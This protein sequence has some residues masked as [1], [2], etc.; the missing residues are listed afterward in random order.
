VAGASHD[1][2]DEVEVLDALEAGDGGVGVAEVR[3]LAL[4]ELEAGQ[5]SAR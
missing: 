1:V 2:D 5:R 4:C 3:H